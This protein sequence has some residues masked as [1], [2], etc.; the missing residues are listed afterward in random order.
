M[1]RAGTGAPRPS[2]IVAI[3]AASIPLMPF[4]VAVEAPTLL[5]VEQHAR[6]MIETNRKCSTRSERERRRSWWC[7][8]MKDESTTPTGKSW[9]ASWEIGSANIS[10]PLVEDAIES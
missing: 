1:M 2:G 6:E 7:L 8:A 9:R 3:G 5:L 4:L 10:R